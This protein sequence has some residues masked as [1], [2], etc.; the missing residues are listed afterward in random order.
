MNIRSIIHKLF[1]SGAVKFGTFTLKSGITSPIYIDLRAT[2]SNPKLLCDIGEALYEKVKNRSFDLICGVPYTA[3]PF[4]TVISIHHNIPM[5]LR[6][7]EKKEYGT[8]KQIEGTYHP[9]Q[10]CLIVE[11]VITSGQSV[12]ET[13]ASLFQENL[14]VEDIAVFVDRE[15]GGAKRLAEKGFRVHSICT[16]T[17]IVHTLREDQKINEQIANSVL[18]FI[19]QHQVHV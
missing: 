3:L 8:G 11:D 13:A 16:I 19:K 2:I 14:V 17:E 1:E 9:S 6:R 10:R 5:I 4:A 18:E 15:Q 12:L 7:K